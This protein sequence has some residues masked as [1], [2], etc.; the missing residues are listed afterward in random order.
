VR[1]QNARI[2][3]AGQSSTRLWTLA[4]ALNRTSG[5]SGSASEDDPAER[6]C[7]RSRT[8]LGSTPTTLGGSHMT[9]SLGGRYDPWPVKRSTDWLTDWL[10][11]RHIAWYTSPYPWCHSVVLVPGWTDWLANI[12]T[13]RLTGSG[14]ASEACFA[15]MRKTNPTLL[16]FLFGWKPAIFHEKWSSVLCNAAACSWNTIPVVVQWRHSFGLVS[17]SLGFSKVAHC[18][19]T[20]TVLFW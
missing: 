20:A 3:N 13:D 19:M 6:G 1:N 15:T 4:Q 2:S 8:I 18:N 16:Y 5:R 17:Y 11:D 9:A 10:T 7:S 12:S 14:G